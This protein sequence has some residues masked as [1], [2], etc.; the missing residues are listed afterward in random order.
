MNSLHPTPI[1]NQ[2]HL[3]PKTMRVDAFKK[4]LAVQAYLERLQHA[5]RNSAETFV[6]GSQKTGTVS[7][8][9]SMKCAGEATSLPDGLVFGPSLLSSSSHRPG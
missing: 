9:Q 3:V 4:A 7:R 6:P 8:S 2:A 5:L 1:S